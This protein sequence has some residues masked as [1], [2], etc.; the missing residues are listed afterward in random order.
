MRVLLLCG[1]LGAGKTTL[2]RNIVSTADRRT[3]VLVNDVGRLGIDADLVRGSNDL[4]VVELP[5]GCVCCSLRGSLVETVARI[6]REVAPERLIVEPSGVATPSDIVR[7]LQSPPLD[8]VTHL[9][10]VVG[11]VDSST[12]LK[13]FSSGAMGSFFTDQIRNSDVVLL[14]KTDLVD[15][16]VVERVAGIVREINPTGVVV[17]ARYCQVEL[18]EVQRRAPLYESGQTL[19][20]ETVALPLD[21]PFAVAEVDA[22][23]A[24]LASGRYG[25]VA[26][27]KGVFLTPEGPVYADLAGERTQRRAFPEGT[28]G[29]FVAIGYQL[30]EAGLR[31]RLGLS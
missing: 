27:A 21:R 10:V 19:S 28:D 1:F 5:G 4:D 12:F 15:A 16:D 3:A 23:F 14:N 26:R 22:L 9:E 2:L 29:K 8:Q 24:D 6:A 31:T 13:F 25:Q 18:P 17:P 20:F 30:D 11:V 7:T